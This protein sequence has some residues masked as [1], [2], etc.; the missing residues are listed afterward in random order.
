MTPSR[1]LRVS[2]VVAELARAEAFYRDALAFRTVERGSTDA[3]VLAVLGAGAAAEIVMR[4][5][6]QEIA[7]VR[8]AAPGRPYP[9]DS[10][11]NDLWFQHLAIVVDDIDAA[12]AHLAAQS[13]WRPISENGPELLPPETGGV[14]AFK[15]RDPD[16]HPLELIWFPEGEGRP[17]WHRRGAASPFLGIDHSALAVTST[18]RSLDFYRALGLKVDTRSLNQGPAQS[19]L[20][21]LAGT[22]VRVTGLRPGAPES[23]GLELL[24]YRPPGRRA[25]AIGANDIQTDWVTL[26]VGPLAGGMPQARRDPDGHLMILVDQ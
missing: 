18:S 21:G 24:A 13:G 16:G 6:A 23:M 11:S 10:H 15:F 7:L 5:G 4:L 8:F 3:T 9:A 1:I 12:Y 14:R 17:V 19:R 2:R 20:D 25:E 26:G 22:R